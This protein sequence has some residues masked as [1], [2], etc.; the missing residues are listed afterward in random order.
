MPHRPVPTSSVKNHMN[1][2]QCGSTKVV[3]GKV[4]GGHHMSSSF[5]PS[6]IPLFTFRPFVRL[7]NRETFCA[8]IECGHI[9]SG[10][11]PL[12]LTHLIERRGADDEI[13]NKGFP[14]SSFGVDL[15]PVATLNHVNCPECGSANRVKGKVTKYRDKAKF[16]PA[17][18]R[19]FTFRRSARLEKKS[20][21]ACIQ[22]GHLWSHVV[23]SDLLHLFKRSGTEGIKRMIFS[24]V[25]STH[26][27]NTHIS[28][29]EKSGS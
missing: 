29:S 2:A 21:S 1:C 19:F 3:K 28:Q 16:H 26:T 17:D 5:L 27:A 14:N 11:V 6:G 8:C 7:V 9:W 18:I 24:D 23:R 12:D 10:V 20:F 25:A 4:S 15:T 22:C 13:K